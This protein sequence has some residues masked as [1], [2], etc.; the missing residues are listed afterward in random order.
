[1]ATRVRKFIEGL[2]VVINGEKINIDYS[3][4]WKRRAIDISDKVLQ[5][6]TALLEEAA[7]QERD[8]L[9]PLREVLE[10][11][12]ELAQLVEGSYLV[13]GWNVPQLNVP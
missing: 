11:V 1:M 8:S 10:H 2:E 3:G 12:V 4:N 5:K 6:E 9:E 7:D 13:P